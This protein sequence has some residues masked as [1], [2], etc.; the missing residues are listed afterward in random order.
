MT[1]HISYSKT[2]ELLSKSSSYWS[3]FI[4]YSG[5]TECTMKIC[6]N[7]YNINTS[8]FIFRFP[9]FIIGISHFY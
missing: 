7:S 8:S 4:I 6:Q 5:L 3:M 9:P 1:Q 2:S